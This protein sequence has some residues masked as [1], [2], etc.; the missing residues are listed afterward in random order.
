MFLSRK[1]QIICAL[2]SIFQSPAEAKG[3]PASFKRVRV[4]T[5]WGYIDPKNNDVAAIAEKCRANLSI[6]EFYSTTEFLERISSNRSKEIQYDLLI[7]SDTAYNAKET[8]F[9]RNSKMRLNRNAKLYSSTIS[10][11]YQNNKYNNA[12]GIF[13]LSLAG[14]LVNRDL[15]KF[16]NSINLEDIFKL[17]RDN[18]F[19]LMDDH[20]EISTLFNK[21]E[22]TERKSSC[23]TNARPTFPS[24]EKL[25][26]LIGKSKVVISGDL[27][28]IT[29]HPRFAVAY[30][31]S[32]D[33]IQKL[34][35]QSNL[36]FFLH[37]VLSHS[38][39]DL[40]TLTGDSDEAKCVAHEFTSKAF[41]EKITKKSRYFSPY[42]PVPSDDREFS[43]LQNQF[44]EQF[45]NLGKIQRV[46]Q[47]ESLEIDKK[48]QLFKILFG[49]KL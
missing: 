28:E 24:D 15:M 1:F 19:V 12:T 6:D 18:V 13:Q 16:H 40:L 32:G 34:N 49:S 42:G 7:F 36:D 11:F 3:Q 2:L 17:A 27:A 44:F 10:R 22:C 26:K 33:A 8:A 45:S 38:S 29:K 31:W 20:M 9:I 23:R 35:S 30:T 25:R 21:W 47:E 5:W 14:F 41:I 4:L 37:P 39:M 43:K 46:T 48:W